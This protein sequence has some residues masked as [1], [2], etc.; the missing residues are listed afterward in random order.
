MKIGTVRACER[1]ASTGYPLPGDPVPFLLYPPQITVTGVVLEAGVIADVRGHLPPDVR[2]AARRQHLAE[3]ASVA[4]VPCGG[5]NP[6]LP[7][8]HAAVHGAKW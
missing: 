2:I 7:P 6:P 8:R 1:E 5:G 3:I 4:G